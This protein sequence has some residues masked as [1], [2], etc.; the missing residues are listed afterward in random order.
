MY[1]PTPVLRGVEVPDPALR[2]CLQE[3]I[4]AESITRTEELKILNCSH[5]GISDLSGLAA[6]NALERLKLSANEIRNLVE[7]E[8]LTALREL[9]LDKNRIVDPVPLY[10]LPHLTRLDLSGNPGLQ[11]PRE[12]GFAAVNSVLLPAHCN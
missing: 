9:I 7:L 2:A 11:C 10:R 3:V 1:S 4:S 6:F 8:K 5:A 12:A